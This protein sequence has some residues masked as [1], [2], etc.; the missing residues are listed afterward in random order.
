MEKLYN[1][2]QEEWFDIWLQELID[3]NYIL[4]V[5]DQSITGWTLAE[6][7]A[8]HY[9]YPKVLYKG[10][11]RERT[12]MT[13]KK[14]LLHKGATY[15][16]DRVII[17]HPKAEGIFFTDINK[18]KGSA[19]TVDNARYFLAHSSPIGYFSPVDVKSPHR[20]GTTSG[21]VG[22]SIKKKWLWQ[23]EQIYANQC[24]QY[25]NKPLKTTKMYLWPSTF[26]PQR[27]LWTDKL[28]KKRTIPAHKGVPLWEVRSLKDYLSCIE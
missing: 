12:R 18:L 6:E 2:T 26:T 5:K 11:A 15:T 1:P 25:P 24:V 17:W 28:T 27:F 16:P 20:K 23:K 9:N 13:K 22:F 14:F 10:T 7:V 19:S 8:I 3:L 21:D 4:E